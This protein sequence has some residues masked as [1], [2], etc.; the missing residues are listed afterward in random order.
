SSDE[1]PVLFSIAPGDT[2]RTIAANLRSANLIADADLFI[3]YVQLHDLDTQLRSGDYY[4][5]RTQSIVQIAETLVDPNSTLIVFTILPG[6]RIEEIAEL[7]TNNPR[8]PFSGEDFLL[9]VG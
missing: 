7:I 2:P 4:L 6:M 3:D 5:Y 9:T 8:I 1:T